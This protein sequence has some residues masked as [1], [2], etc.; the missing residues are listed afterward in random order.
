M[1]NKRV[2]KLIL[3]A[4]VIMANLS[5]ANEYKPVSLPK[6]LVLG[7]S[8]SAAYN[9]NPED[10]WVNLL[11]L[12]LANQ[13]EV[14]NASISGETTSGGLNRLP[15]LLAKH[16]PNLILIEL[17]AND[18]LRGLPTKLIENNL[19]KIIQLA[20]AKEANLVLLGIYLPPNYG[21]KYLNQFT[22]IYPRLAKQ[23]SIDYL[24]FLLNGV[25][26][27]A[28]LM[29]NDGLHPKAEAQPIILENVWPLV[30]PFF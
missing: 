24:P 29:Q 7:D 21:A 27:N 26:E 6:V 14:I 1:L 18:G 20:K 17:G 28:S 15:N 3:I 19:N 25:A 4:C 11:A 23:H 12:R 2:I 22:S 5:W 8:L 30:K 10:G 9:L 13:A 16:Q